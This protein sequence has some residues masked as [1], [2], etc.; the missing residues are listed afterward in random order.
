MKDL[1][2]YS[3]PRGMESMR[4]LRNIFMK[5]SQTSVQALGAITF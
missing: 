1:V 3:G 5:V 4:W 2:D